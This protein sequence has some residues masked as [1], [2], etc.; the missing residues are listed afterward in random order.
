MNNFKCDRCGKNAEIGDEIVMQEMKSIYHGRLLCQ[1][2]DAQILIL[3]TASRESAIEG[4]SIA[5]YL[6]KWRKIYG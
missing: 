5:E 3:Q 2:C 4:I 1:S 6:D